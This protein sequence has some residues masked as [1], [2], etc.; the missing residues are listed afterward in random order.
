MDHILQECIGHLPMHGKEEVEAVSEPSALSEGPQENSHWLQ[1]LP[2]EIWPLI[3]DSFPIMST[4][5]S[6]QYAFV[7][8]SWS[9]ID[10]APYELTTDL[11]PWPPSPLQPPLIITLAFNSNTHLAGA[12]ACTGRR[13]R[14][15]SSQTRATPTTSLMS[16]TQPQES[17]TSVHSS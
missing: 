16:S 12:T 14:S 1:S 7:Q 6:D 9:G 4:R 17:L 11:L 15:S 5:N 13:R 10:F 2:L 3:W 8:P